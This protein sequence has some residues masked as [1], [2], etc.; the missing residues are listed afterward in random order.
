M[1]K[2]PKD[3]KT[4]LET[5]ASLSEGQMDFLLGIIATQPASLNEKKYIRSIAEKFKAESGETFPEGIADAIRTALTINGAIQ[6]EE[7]SPSEI[8]EGIAK[9]DELEVNPELRTVLQERLTA[10]IGAESVEVSKKARSL[11]TGN[12]RNYSNAKIVT[13]VRPVFYQREESPDAKKSWSSSVVVHTLQI[14]FD[15]NGKEEKFFTVMDIRD[16]KQ[17][18]A[19]LDTAIEADDNIKEIWSANSFPVADL[20]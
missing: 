10:L 12:E 16:I 7:I 19:V 5:L 20:S 15:C 2:M 8:A 1:A 9:D 4:G 3:V 14:G 17:L 18:K 11:W 13:E 6:D